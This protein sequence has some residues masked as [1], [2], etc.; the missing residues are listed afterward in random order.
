MTILIKEIKR[1]R[2][3]QNPS[4]Y[5]VYLM[6][7]LIPVECHHVIGDDAKD[8]KI[9][10]LAIATNSISLTKENDINNIINQVSF[11]VKTPTFY[12]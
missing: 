8:S 3:Q 7:G 6:A 5:L 4:E 11:D 1:T 2:N 9:M 12:A 10:D